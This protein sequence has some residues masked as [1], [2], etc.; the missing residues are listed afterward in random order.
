MADLKGT[1]IR[2]DGTAYKCRDGSVE[3][4]EFLGVSEGVVSGVN[5]HWLYSTVVPT[6]N[7]VL[8]NEG[9]PKDIVGLA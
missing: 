2:A 1:D 4:L 9:H 8:F 7:I 3:I 5:H 6:G